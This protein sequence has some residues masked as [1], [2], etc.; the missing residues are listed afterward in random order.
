VGLQERFDFIIVGG[1]SAGCVL[2]HRLSAQRGYSV[3]LLEAGPD[4]EPFW[5]RTPAGV[6]HL[7][8]DGRVNWRFQTEPEPALESRQIYCPRGRIIG[9]SSAINGM[10]YMRGFAD[11]YDRWAA[12]GNAGWSWSDVLPYFKKAETSTTRQ[13]DQRGSAGP[14]TV[15]QPGRQQASTHA[16]VD[17]SAAVGL[18]RRMDLA[19]ARPDGVGYAQHTIDAGVRSSTARAYLRHARQRPNLT[20]VGDALCTRLFVEGGIARGVEYRHGNTMRVAL[21]RRETILSA[22][23]IGSPQVLMLSGIG[24][25]EHLRELAIPVT[26]ALP[27]VG[28][29]LQ[30]HLA[31]NA[32]FEVLDGYSLNRTLSGWRKYVRGAGYLV[33]RG[34]PLSYG[35]SHAVAFARSNPCI[36]VP[37][38][39]L[40]FRPLSLAFDSQQR[41]RL[42]PFPGVQIAGAMLRPQSR[43]RIRLRSNDP[44]APPVIQG[45]FLSAPDD[46]R[47][48]LAAVEWIRR[49]A[50]AEPLSRTIVR[51]VLPGPQVR[52][53]EDLLAFIRQRAETIY[54]PV[55]TCRM[56]RD[57]EAV[58]DHRLRLHGVR[59]LRVVDASVMPRIVKIGRAHV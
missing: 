52:S 15:S 43:G 48:M 39:Q 7:Y 36:G 5:V 9:G 33:T 57:P 17:S 30:D 28:R 58:V 16:F 56:G 24:D 55:G 14:L 41:L 11:D 53:R 42:H 19:D 23:A 35:V 38:I 27:G 50:A 37:D 8:F 10:L 13:S 47:V 34:G 22:G 6:G 20:V 44:A 21:A 49:I 40:T 51:E 54:H 26:H 31:V 1:G 18:T 29:N 12:D 32:A 46:T 59:R 3:L 2:A 25:P 4:R 45:S